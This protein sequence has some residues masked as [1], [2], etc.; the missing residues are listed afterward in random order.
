MLIYIHTPLY[1]SSKHLPHLVEHCVIHQIGSNINNFINYSYDVEWDT[2]AMYS[3][4]FIPNHYDINLF[5]N[6]I[7]TKLNK[8]T[9]KYEEKIIKKELE[10]Y[11]Y[12]QKLYEN[13]SKQIYPKKINNTKTSRI[14]F[15]ELI[16]YHQKYYHKENII[17]CD[18][19]FNILPKHWR[20]LNPCNKKTVFD[21]N[22]FTKKTIISSHIKTNLIFKEYKNWKDY[23]FL[24]FLEVLLETWWAY[25][26]RQKGNKYNYEHQLLALMPEHI[27]LSILVTNDTNISEA[28]FWEYKKYFIHSL[29]YDYA[30]KWT[31]INALIVSQYI[32]TKEITNFITKI[33]YRDVLQYW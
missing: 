24:F 8:D 23:Y 17:V 16:N 30:K 18:D 2:F 29:N 27:L 32:K 10:Y 9:I 25:I 5:L 1:K 28:F 3:V 26:H 15:Q 12:Y 11:N 21:P 14:S 7:T 31:I 19:N 4:F 13:A 6:Q 33:N 20:Q 22:N